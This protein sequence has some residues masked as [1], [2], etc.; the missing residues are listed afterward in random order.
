[1]ETKTSQSFFAT[2][3][4]WFRLLFLLFLV[5]GTIGIIR[6]HQVTYQHNEGAIFG[7]TYHIRYQSPT[8]FHPEIVKELS[9]VD[10]ALSLFNP[11]SWLSHYN[12]GEQPSTNNMA[13]EVITLA[14]QVSDSTEGAFDI[15]VAPLVNAWGFGYKSGQWPTPQEVDSLRSLVGYKR[16]AEGKK[17]MLDCGAIAK[18]YG[19][20]RVA[21]VLRNHGVTNY[22]VEIGGEVVV[23]GHNPEG[24]LWQIGVAKPTDQTNEMQEV[25][26][27][28]NAALATS[29]NYRNYHTDSLGHKVAHTI[30]PRLGHPVQ[31]TLLSA[32]VMASTC[33]EADAYA[34]A[35]MVMGL[36]AA[37]AFVE[38]HPA[39]KVYFIYSTP[40]NSLDV[41]STLPQE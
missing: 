9:K 21:R 13:N 33:A 7:T 6:S 32:T 8:D 4:K 3:I 38:K 19:V 36:D 40:D 12:A 14:M 5:V 23:S 2:H 26:Q 22:M 15:T 24:K 16:Y 17:V 29:G 10:A 28:D 30:D 25:I 18:G 27:L 1:M 37:K 35:F 41:Y 31:H 39:L 20:D 34:T 11:D